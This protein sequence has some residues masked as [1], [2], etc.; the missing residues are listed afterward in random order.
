MNRINLL[1]HSKTVPNHVFIHM[2]EF[3]IYAMYDRIQNSKMEGAIYGLE[4]L[5]T[6]SSIQNIAVVP[7][8]TIDSN[9]KISTM[10]KIPIA[11]N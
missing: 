6:K 3:D 10:A 8:C 5:I 1:F 4:K 7:P 9:K 11:G 2:D